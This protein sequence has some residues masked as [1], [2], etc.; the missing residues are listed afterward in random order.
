[1]IPPLKKIAK[2]IRKNSSFLITT[3]AQPDGDGLGAQ[4]ALHFYLKKI[5]KQSLVINSDPTPPKFQL[6]DPRH[7]I[8]AYTPNMKLTPVDVVVVMDT[9]DWQMLGPMQ[10]LIQSMKVP[11]IFIDH[12]VTELDEPNEHLIDEAFG[13]TGELVYTLLRWIKAD[14]DTE[15]A[16]ALYVAIMT[17]TSSFRF[18]RTTAHSHLIASELL[19]KGVLPEQVYQSIYARDSISKVRLFGNVLEN[20]QTSNH[21]RVAWLSVSRDTRE[22]Y[23]ATIE[24]TEAFSNQLTLIAGVDIGIVFREDS[25]S[26]IKVSLRGNGEIPVFGIA[27]KFGGGGHRHAAGMKINGTL[28]QAITQVCREANEVLKGY[29][30]QTS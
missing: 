3:H 24:D 26:Q 21:G 5:G 11:V 30:Q 28:Q 9:H 10:P 16:L 15:M 25:E 2:I 1:M 17:D 14:I 27:K 29:P 6:V 18:K 12:H 13:S 7:E 4:M 22:K 8:Q 20:I 19:Q 23:Q